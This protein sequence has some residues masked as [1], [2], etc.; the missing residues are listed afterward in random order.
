MVAEHFGFEFAS[1]ELAV[2]SCHEH[3]L[4]RGI[5]VGCVTAVLAALDAALTLT[6][7][8]PLLAPLFA[9]GLR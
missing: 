2:R 6:A 7:I 5:V 3:D 8:A 4:A 1:R 9:G